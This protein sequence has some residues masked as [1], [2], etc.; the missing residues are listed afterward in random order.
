MS[1]ASP[2]CAC[3]HEQNYMYIH[4]QIVQTMHYIATIH[5]YMRTCTH[6]YIYKYLVLPALGSYRSISWDH[7]QHDSKPSKD[8]ITHREVEEHERENNL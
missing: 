4:M 2:T 1:S 8:G 6:A 5:A 3:M 7:Q